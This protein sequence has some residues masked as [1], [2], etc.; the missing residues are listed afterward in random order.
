[1]ISLQLNFE[2]KLDILSLYHVER[3][4]HC[5]PALWFSLVCASLRLKHSIL[6][7]E[8]PLEI[9]PKLNLESRWSTGEK[10][11]WLSPRSLGPIT[12]AF[13][14]TSTNYQ[15]VRDFLNSSK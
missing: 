12:S 6:I 8:V 11:S 4:I 14:D 2:E 7:I 9:F 1:M 15:E 10:W 3:A 13:T 5:S